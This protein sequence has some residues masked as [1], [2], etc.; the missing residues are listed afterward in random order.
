MGLLHPPPS[1]ANSQSTYTF[2]LRIINIYTRRT[3]LVYFVWLKLSAS[4]VKLSFR[5]QPQF[6]SSKVT[7]RVD[8]ADFALPIV[9]CMSDFNSFLVFW[10]N[11]SAWTCS[12]FG[13]F[14]K[15]LLETRKCFIL[16]YILHTYMHMYL[17]SYSE[18]VETVFFQQ[19][20]FCN[21]PKSS[22]LDFS[23]SIIICKYCKTRKHS[24][25]ISYCLPCVS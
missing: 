15:R 25:I 14:M 21:L 23:C 6:S 3:C 11:C 4:P 18:F 12:W 1:L 7:S 20:D 13:V 2:F 22:I 16:T 17:K 8:F 9:S 5:S 19:H 24:Y 10:S